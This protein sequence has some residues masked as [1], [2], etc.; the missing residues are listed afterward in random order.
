MSYTRILEFHTK[1]VTTRLS[2]IH[3]F[4]FQVFVLTVDCTWSVDVKVEKSGSWRTLDISILESTYRIDIVRC[5]N[6]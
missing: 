5:G 6:L 2:Q 4:E 3:S 1:R